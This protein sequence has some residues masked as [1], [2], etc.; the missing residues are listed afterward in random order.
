MHF[1][2]LIQFTTYYARSTALHCTQKSRLLEKLAVT[3]V[4][5]LLACALTEASWAC[6]RVGNLV[7]NSK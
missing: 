5:M 3:F 1:N 4:S 7:I 2:F 6:F